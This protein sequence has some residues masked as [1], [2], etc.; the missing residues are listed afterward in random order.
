MGRKM[1]P[2]YY[3]GIGSRRTPAEVELTIR[4]VAHKLTRL[5]FTLRS[6]GADGADR[7]FETYSERVEIWLPWK[8]FNYHA[9]PYYK[10]APR[11]YEI[12]AEIH[13]AWDRL[14]SGAKHLHARNVHQVLGDDLATPVEFVVCWTPGGK[15]VGGTAT[16][17]N[18]AKR[19]DIEVI[20]LYDYPA[21]LVSMLDS[22][23]DALVAA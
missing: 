1:R 8:G 14:S 17:I 20:N 4:F 11:A 9:S 13:P 6:G 5:G 10:L 21:L 2:R 19:H 3:A 23:L 22:K 12:A 7:M 16:A 15:I 18:L